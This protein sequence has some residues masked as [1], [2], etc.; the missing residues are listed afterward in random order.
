MYTMTWYIKREKNNKKEGNFRMTKRIMAFAAAV[1]MAASVFTGC[2]S[3]TEDDA[4]AQTSVNVIENGTTAPSGEEVTT[5]EGDFS[6]PAAQLGVETQPG[7]IPPE[8][9]ENQETT[10]PPNHEEIINMIQNGGGTVTT[11]APILK[12]YNVDCTTRYGYN[13]LNDAEKE[14]YK[15]ILEAAN[16]IRTSLRVD[17]S[18]TDEM[19]I[20]VY[21]CVYMQEPQLFWLSSKKVSKGKLWYWEIDPELI[22]SMQKEIDATVGKILAEAD[23]KS[24]YEKLKVFHDYIALNNNF[25]K[26]SGYNQTIYGGFVNGEIQC[27]GYAKSIQYLC[28]LTGIESTVV[29][30]TNESGDSHAWNVVKVDGKWYNLDTTWDDPILS[31]VVKTNIRYRY[32]LV[33]DEWIHNKSHF[34]VNKKTT[35]TQ[36]TY[37]TPPACTSDDMNYFKVTKQLYSEEASADTALRAK[38]KECAASNTRAVEIRV[39]SQAVYD[40][41]TKNLKDYASWIKS[42]NSAVTSVSS[43]CDPNTLVIELDLSF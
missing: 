20:K 38:L 14:L 1:L 31:N 17:D 6:D 18:V 19:W 10:L 5:A 30:G 28:D 40:A 33:P 39:T 2:G 43:N 21:G 13:Q 23:G 29:V 37:F 12:E 7:D 25:V 27:E 16:S 3:K 36:V 41:V 42:E 9:A 26:E 8:D 32:F 11:K 4:Q 24:D 15:Q 35:G 22:A 34:N